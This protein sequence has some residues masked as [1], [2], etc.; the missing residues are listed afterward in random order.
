MNGEWVRRPTHGTTV[1]FVHGILSSGDT[2]WRH[3]NGA[4]WPTIL[5]DEEF[6][7]FVGVYVFTYQTTLFGGTY[8]LGDAVDALKEQTRLDGVLDSRQI[9]FVCH[10]MGGIVVR[11]FLV[12][13]PTDFI[14][15]NQALG[16]FL[17]ASPSLGSSYAD[18]LSPLPRPWSTPRQA[19]FS[20]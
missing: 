11:N 18:W 12:E 10:S 7:K 19:H 5:A 4:C 15:S 2:C 6:L 3:A 1:V 14:N 20:S 17:V 8:R 16:L 13:R 9:I